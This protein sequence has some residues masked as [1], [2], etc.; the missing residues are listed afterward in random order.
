VVFRNGTA[1]RFDTRKASKIVS[2][3][4]HTI[5][6]HLGVGK[7][8]DFCYGCDLSKEYVTINSEYHT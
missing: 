3:T 7:A 6:V 5:T 4:E 1:A 8:E 2:K